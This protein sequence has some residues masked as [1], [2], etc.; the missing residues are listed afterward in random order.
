MRGFVTA[1]VA[2]ALLVPDRAHAAGAAYQVDTA[3]V[4]EAGAC[5]VES[6][7]S[8]ASNRDVIGAV[9][10]AGAF[11]IG[12]PLELSSEFTRQRAEGEWTT[13]VGHT[14]KMNQAPSAID[15]SAVAVTATGFFDLTAGQNTG[16]EVV[17]PATIRLSNN[18]R[19]NL[20]AGWL[21]DRVGERQYAFYGAGVDL[22][23]SDNVWTLTVEVFGQAGSAEISSVV[24][25]RFQAGLRFRPVDRFN[26]DLI[27]GRNIQGENANWLT[28]ATVI[29]FPPPE[30]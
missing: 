2:A 26:V 11:D 22:R 28:L 13:S 6:W 14:A 20:N 18:M 25:P 8:L 5:K 23:T 12:R 1:L 21:W 3:E 24:Q 16:V 19:I 9:R 17:I 4:S 7:V 10:P 29:R 27:Y 15:A 30:K